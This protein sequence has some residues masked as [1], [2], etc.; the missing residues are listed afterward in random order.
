M[1]D[2]ATRTYKGPRRPA[3]V[4]LEPSIVPNVAREVAAL[5]R[6]LGITAVDIAAVSKSGV[7]SNLDAVGWTG[8]WFRIE[9]GLA[10]PTPLNSLFDSIV[11]TRPSP[12]SVHLNSRILLGSPSC[13][14]AR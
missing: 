5:L 6:R 12:T 3:S 4:T 9:R 14:S 13:S 10:L 11:R 2:D 1:F 8:L 7:R